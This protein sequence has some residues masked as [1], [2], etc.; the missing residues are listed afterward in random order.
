M[1][2][3]QWKAGVIAAERLV[4]LHENTVVGQKEILKEAKDA[5]DNAVR[6]LRT[7]I[8]PDPQAAMEFPDE[9]NDAT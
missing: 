8:H 5:Y 7:T 2:D 1:D 3:A 4:A 9:S 6:N